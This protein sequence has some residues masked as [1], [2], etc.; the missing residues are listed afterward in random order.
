MV[1]A[2]RQNPW[3]VLYLIQFNNYDPQLYTVKNVYLQLFLTSKPFILSKYTNVLE[4]GAT[5]T[6]IDRSQKIVDLF[7]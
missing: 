3:L 6:L 2:L 7:P 1:V 5:S 4:S